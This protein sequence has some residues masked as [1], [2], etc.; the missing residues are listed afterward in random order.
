[1]VIWWQHLLIHQLLGS[2]HGQCRL[3]GRRLVCQST[4]EDKSPFE[5]QVGRPCSAALELCM[6]GRGLCRVMRGQAADHC[7]C[8]LLQLLAMF[9]LERS[10][11]WPWARP[12]G[13]GTKLVDLLAQLAA[14]GAVQDK[15]DPV[16]T[17]RPLD[18]FCSQLQL[19]DRHAHR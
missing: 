5:K 14:S 8:L 3:P 6:P 7:L 10:C 1:M 18:Q 15:L 11:H 17:S 13:P 12:Q 16:A 19:S 2:Q 4:R 9:A